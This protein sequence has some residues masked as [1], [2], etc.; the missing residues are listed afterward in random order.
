MNDLS[1]FGGCGGGGSS[2]GGRG[3]SNAFTPP[4]WRHDCTSNHLCVVPENRNG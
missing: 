4:K 1:W 2:G 3:G